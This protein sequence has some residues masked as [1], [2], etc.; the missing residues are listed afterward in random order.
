MD[1]RNWR[2]SLAVEVAPQQLPSVAGYQPVALVILAK[3]Y[4]RPGDLDWEPVALSAAGSMTHVSLDRGGVRLAQRV[5][6]TF[7][8]PEAPR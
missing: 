3:A 4:I 5:R 6:L 7:T 8:L 2:A 1:E